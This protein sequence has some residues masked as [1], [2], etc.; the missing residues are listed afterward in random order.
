M[1]RLDYT[2]RYNQREMFTSIQNVGPPADLAMSL[3]PLVLRLPW[4]MPLMPSCAATAECDGVMHRI[5]TSPFKGYAKKKSATRGCFIWLR[6]P[7]HPPPPPC[8][9]K[10]K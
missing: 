6:P 8:F 4:K 5:D 9:L 3:R 10:R 2:M 7:R 1:T